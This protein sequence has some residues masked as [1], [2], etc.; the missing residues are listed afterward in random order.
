[1]STAVAPRLG[2]TKRQMAC[3]QAIA[4]HMAAHG[5]APTYDELCTTLGCTS[6]GAVSN[7]MSE[8][9]SRGW[10]SYVTG[11]R[12]S[13]VLLPPAGSYELPAELN[14][15]LLAFC[16][17][18]DEADPASVVADAVTLFLDGAGGIVAS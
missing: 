10:I 7:M 15:K 11:R 1:M 5:T 14:A 13:I 17:A 12:S 4:S 18:H 16:T 6:R 3:Y 9:R 2:L 8:L